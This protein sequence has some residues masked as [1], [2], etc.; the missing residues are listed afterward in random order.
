M[1]DCELVSTCPYY[2]GMIDMPE[3]CREEYC[4]GEYG[5]CGR[6]LAWS[7]LERER[8]FRFR[9]EMTGGETTLNAK[10]GDVS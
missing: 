3:G 1:N 8:N 9:P 5:W 6:Y 4:R 2:T 7:A 10:S